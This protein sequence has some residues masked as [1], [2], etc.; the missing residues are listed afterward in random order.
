MGISNIQIVSSES[1]QHRPIPMLYLSLDIH[2]RC[3]TRQS[4]FTNHHFIK[5]SIHHHHSLPTR[6]NPPYTRTL[7]APLTANE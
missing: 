3:N 5:S 1:M 2:R 7:N 4:W 6:I